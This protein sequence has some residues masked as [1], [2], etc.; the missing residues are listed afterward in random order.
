[1]TILMEQPTI[2]EQV[3]QEGEP[4]KISLDENLVRT[5][6]FSDRPKLV[7]VTERKVI[8]SSSPELKKTKEF[9]KSLILEAWNEM[10]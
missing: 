9:F 3:E 10:V 1:M 4:S 8:R 7:P 5:V 2:I 6:L